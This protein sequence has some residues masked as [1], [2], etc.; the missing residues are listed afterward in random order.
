MCVCVCVW[1][2]QVLHI[3]MHE[4]VKLHVYMIAGVCI[5][6]WMLV[7]ME[8]IFNDCFSCNTK[9]LAKQLPAIY[10][11][12]SRDFTSR[13]ASSLPLCRRNCSSFTTFC[14]LLKLGLHR[15]DKVLFLIPLARFLC[16]FDY[17]IGF[18]VIIPQSFNAKYAE[19]KCIFF[20]C[21]N[22]DLPL[23]EN[24]RKS[25]YV[26]VNIN[27]CTYIIQPHTC[28]LFITH[29][30]GFVWMCKSVCRFV[31]THT[32]KYPL[33]TTHSLNRTLHMVHFFIW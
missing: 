28:T 12:L 2:L 11:Y 26:C 24:A 8:L 19:E 20:S 25:T 6:Q 14:C 4:L 29:V 33:T 5:T 21:W 10:V 27:V 7:S 9:A 1:I 18:S 13:P 17:S 23:H 3:N 16:T 15:R 30:H 31:H 32:Y 22:F